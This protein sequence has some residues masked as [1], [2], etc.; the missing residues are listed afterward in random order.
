MVI[1]KFVLITS[2]PGHDWS[3]SG[4]GLHRFF[5]HL[6]FF[7]FADETLLKAVAIAFN[8]F[9][10]FDQMS[11]IAYLLEVRM[12]RNIIGNLNKD[13]CNGNDDAR[14]Q[15]SDWLH[16][17]NKSC[18][19]C[20]THFRII[21]WRSQPND[22]VRKFPNLR[23]SRQLEHTT[24]NLSFSIFTSTVLLPVH[25]QRTLATVKDARKKQ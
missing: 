16:E 17:E 2:N 7:F 10:S 8:D 4:Q 13:D 1:V 12:M 23:F 9:S 15:W 14:K 21:L 6:S 18:C 3:I 19:T 20:R 22:N 11:P 25:L 5:V 24:V